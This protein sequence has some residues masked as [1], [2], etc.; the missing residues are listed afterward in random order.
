[1]ADVT[2]LLDAAA[3][4]DP[5]A[6]AE[7][8]PLVYDALRALAAARLAQ[9]KPGQTLQATALVHE[10]Y[11]RLVGP[12]PDRGW[13]G[14]GHF[15]A[16]AAEAMRRILV[17]QARRKQA[18]KR[19]GRGGRVPLDAADVGFTSPADELLDIDD[20][21]TRLAAED[22]QAAQLIQLRYFAGV[23]ME[24]AAEMVGLSRSTAYEHWAYAR[25]RLKTLLAGE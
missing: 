24:D 4:G 20:A 1:M 25:A 3:A 22:P 12:D 8:L 23:A 2:R 10:A 5:K 17:D 7:V 15:F 6:A 9:E 19:G 21:L 11:L 14:R 18:G 13:N 16:A